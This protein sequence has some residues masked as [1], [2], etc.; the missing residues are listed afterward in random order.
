MDNFTKYAQKRSITNTLG[1]ALNPMEWVRQISSEKYRRLITEIDAV[2]KSMRETALQLKPTAREKLHQARMAFKNRE[3]RRVFQYSFEILDGIRGIF[4]SRIDELE[5]IGR[6]VYDEYAQESM[7]DN[8]IKQ[9]EERQGFS[10]RSNSSLEQEDLVINAGV[11]QWLKEKVPTKKEME[12][13]LFDKLFKNMNGKQQ[14]GARQALLVAERAYDLIQKSFVELDKNRRNIIEYVKLAR[15]YQHQL[16]VEKEQLKKIYLNYFPP[17]AVATP[18]LEA[19][20]VQSVPKP[21][22]EQ[23]TETKPKDE[24]VVSTVQAQNRSVSF[25]R[26]GR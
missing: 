4:T 16:F 13:A 24:K 17:E 3:Y 6:E 9:F 7:S 23:P 26:W 12:G 2:D 20:P 8:E 15:H 5:K 14:E 1:L 11:T 10:N 19:P 18:T 22:L 21:I 25:M